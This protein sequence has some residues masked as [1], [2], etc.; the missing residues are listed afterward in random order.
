M[1]QSIRQLKLT[2]P[3]ILSRLIYNMI[4]HYMI[5]KQKFSQTEWEQ[6]LALEHLWKLGKKRKDRQ[7]SHTNW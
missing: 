3:V 5:Q 1:P 4:M 2:L 6:T 7:N